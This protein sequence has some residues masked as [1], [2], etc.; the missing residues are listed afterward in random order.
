MFLWLQ[1][2]VSSMMS[3]ILLWAG[4]EKVR[5]L[6]TFQ[7]TIRALGLGGANGTALAYGLPLL[8]IALAGF[9]FLAPA[10]I[11][12]P[13]GVAGIGLLFGTAGLL[14]V[15][16]GQRIVCSCFG[17]TGATTLGIR[18][19]VAVPLWMTAALIISLPVPHP[20]PST[21]VLLFALMALLLGVLRAK[22]VAIESLRA[23]GDRRALSGA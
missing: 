21:R 23:R 7:H 5:S 17:A 9:L 15:R 3:V 18:Q 8:E 11:L 20:S 1:L 19:I 22:T 16:R 6:A 4:L 12:V 2:L 10:V 13:I 14:A